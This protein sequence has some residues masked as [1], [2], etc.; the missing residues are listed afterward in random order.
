MILTEEQARQHLH[1]ACIR[2]GGANKLAKRAGVSAAFV[3]QMLS[4]KRLI[5]GKVAT[6]LGLKKVNR[7]ELT[8]V[9]SGPQQERYEKQREAW[10]EQNP[11]IDRL[12]LQQMEEAVAEAKDVLHELQNQNSDN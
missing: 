5:T 9:I 2:E 10:R 1:A 12:R 4:G 6:Y 7:Y 8:R 11:I 3:S